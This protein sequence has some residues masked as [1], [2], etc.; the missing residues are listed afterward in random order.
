MEEVFELGSSIVKIVV[1][2]ITEF[3]GDA[4]VNPANTY[5]YMG[6]GVALAIKRKGGKIIEEEAVKQ[7]PIPIGKA[8]ITTGGLLK[9][10]FVIHAPTVVEPGGSSNPDNVYKATKAALSKAVEEK[11]KKVAFPL[12]G[13]G[14]GGVPPEE[15]AKAMVKAFKEYSDKNLEIYIYVRDLKLFEE[16]KKTIVN[17]GLKPL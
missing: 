14:V 15:S 11:L 6:G 5:G 8:V 3:Q 4:I 10:K 9:V 17:E 16:V 13:A 12:M 1:G 2:D 7:A